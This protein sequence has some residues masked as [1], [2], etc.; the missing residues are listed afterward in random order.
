[1]IIYSRSGI[2]KGV[3]L[4]TFDISVLY[5]EDEPI[6]RLEV[7]NM[8][9]NI[10][11]NVVT[12]TNGVEALNLIKEGQFDIVITDIR[13]PK[14]DGLALSREI[15]KL[16]PE[17]PII[18]TTAY[19]DADCLLD[20][21]EIGINQYI[22]KPIQFEKIVTSLK[23]VYEIKILN[24]KLDQ[25][26][27]VLSQYKSAIDLV[28]VV[29]KT[30]LEGNIIYVNDRF[31]DVIEKCR[32]EIIG[33]NLS[34]LFSLS[35]KDF[36]FD[37]VKA[38]ISKNNLWQKTVEIGNGKY[39]INFTGL[40]IVDNKKVL[41]YIFIGNDITELVKKEQEIRRQLY[42]D[43]LT[44]LPNRLKLMEDLNSIDYT[45]LAIINID[46]F[47]EI[48]DFYG[49]Q[50]GDSIL[51]EMAERLKRYEEEFNYT[52]YKLASDDYAILF[53]G[54]Y[55]KEKALE[56][57]NFLRNSIVDEKFIFE[58]NVIYISI[59]IGVAAVSESETEK[60][61]RIVA[62]RQNL[63]LKAD[64]A[65]KKAKISKKNILM[66]DETFRMFQEFENNI[67]WTRKLKEAITS[68]KIIPYYQPI[69]NNKTGRVEKFET[70]AR[71]IDSDNKCI[72]PS[73][74]LSISKRNKLYSFITKSIFEKSIE[75]FKDLPFEF[76]INISVD[77]IINYE[78]RQFIINKIS[79]NREIQGRFVIE[80]TETEE[81]VKYEE[82]NDF[83][84]ELK[85]YKIKFAIDDFGSGYSNFDHI[86]RLDI[87][88]IKLDAS[89]I[90]NLPFQKNTQ[91]LAKFIVDFAKSL[92]IKTIAE[93][94][95]TKEIYES[96]VE[97]GIDYS[98]GYFFSE[99]LPFEKLMEECINLQFDKK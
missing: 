95:A 98:Q 32:E 49:T 40:P 83:L 66:Y 81:I 33:K 77:D 2:I 68:E 22:L 15:R 84:T 11:R 75:H 16:S 24:E 71:L 82:I 36:L 6:I 97:A 78:T 87:D 93:F 86:I 31:C 74:F 27:T 56:R 79:E 39:Y 59:T 89:I 9:K 37:E 8:L 53:K 46:A 1:L 61:K 72:P 91:L 21:I 73:Y 3:F 25:T 5:V 80:L 44:N 35:D 57:L 19:S 4:N 52:T 14:M 85:N 38:F 41:E 50:I 69:V 10:T 94:V 17:I 67:L 58:D 29:F 88:Y 96:V 65:L 90:K 28:A 92:N 70:L 7:E 47:R 42:T 43:K 64:M 26:R 30:D 12:A 13:L 60:D 55:D 34:E 99:P 62:P 63:M 51:V 54:K 18:I 45:Y 20:A 23:K 48:N 76:S